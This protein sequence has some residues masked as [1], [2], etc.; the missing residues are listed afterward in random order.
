MTNEAI[1]KALDHVEN[2]L[3]RAVEAKKDL[4]IVVCL[5]AIK[6]LM[7]ERLRNEAVQENKVIEV[8]PSEHEDYTKHAMDILD[9]VRN[10]DIKAE[11]GEA[12]MMAIVTKSGEVK[13]A[14]YGDKAQV[15]SIA[16]N[17]IMQATGLQGEKMADGGSQ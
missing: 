11:G 14:G 1:A 8:L 13:M 17:L 12:L 16:F 15:V 7:E 6:I 5:R 2:A 4:D 9:M 3:I 10:G